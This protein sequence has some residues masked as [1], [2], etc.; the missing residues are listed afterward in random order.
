M[1]SLIMGVAN[2]RRMGGAMTTLDYVALGVLI[3]LL[4][5]AVIALQDK[6]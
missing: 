4:L 5:W 3:V 1:L 2:G 6:Q